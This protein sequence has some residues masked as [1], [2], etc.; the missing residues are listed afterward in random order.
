M[1]P[2]VWT[3]DIDLDY[4]APFTSTVARWDIAHWKTSGRHRI[5]LEEV[6]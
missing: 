4:A 1:T 6:A 3:C 2:D 5:S